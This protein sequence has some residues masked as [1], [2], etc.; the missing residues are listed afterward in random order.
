MDQTDQIKEFFYYWF[1]NGNFRKVDI[2]FP[3]ESECG[4]DIMVAVPL[5]GD[6]LQK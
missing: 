6:E 3:I 2:P 1:P 4:K 5:M